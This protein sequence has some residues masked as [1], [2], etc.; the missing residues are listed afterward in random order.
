MKIEITL[1]NIAGTLDRRQ[2]DVGDDDSAE[3]STAIWT[4][5]DDWMLAVG[6]TIHI[7]DAS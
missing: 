4:A 6:D 1:S 2:I 5:I 3:I 7:M